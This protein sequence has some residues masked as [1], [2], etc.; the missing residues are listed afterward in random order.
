MPATITRA[1][2]LPPAA[3]IAREP[4]PTPAPAA[5][6]APARVV[7][8]MGGED[9]T[10]AP[11]A[12]PLG[13][14]IRAAL[15]ADAPAEADLAEL[16]DAL[17]PEAARL[18]ADAEAARAR[19]R[20]PRRPAAES[21]ALR[22]AAGDLDHEADRL[23]A[24]RPLIEAALARCGDRQAER[25]RR[26]EEADSMAEAAAKRLRAE[27]ADAAGRLLDLIAVTVEATRAV[28]E[29]NRD[30]PAD[31][32]PL[33]APEDRLGGN[34]ARGTA[35]GP[36]TFTVAEAVLPALGGRCALWPR[37][38]RGGGLL[39]GAD[40]PALD[41]Y[42]WWPTTRDLDAARADLAR[43]TGDNGEAAA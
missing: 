23:T 3:I 21:A 43:M 11:E 41:P 25:R 26:F 31:A 22:Q 10:P 7:R 32:A 20:D 39:H 8:P 24:A 14:R 36:R 4:E 16:L 35:Y 37:D 29:A 30:R 5:D 38:A 18:R 2:P 42:R 17:D 12:A 15:A 40:A 19:A 34:V 33:L 1:D 9:P 27:Y 28:A 13:D 6:P